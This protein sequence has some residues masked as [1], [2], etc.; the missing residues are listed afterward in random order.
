ML[1][2]SKKDILVGISKLD[3]FTII[4]VFQRSNHKKSKSSYI[5][6]SPTSKSEGKFKSLMSEDFLNVLGSVKRTTDFS[7]ANS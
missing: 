7:I 4:S 3:D 1:F 5:E 6:T 2:K